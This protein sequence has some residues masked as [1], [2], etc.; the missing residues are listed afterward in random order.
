MS[1]T[2]RVL[3]IEKTSIHDG[4]GLR[5]VVFLKGCPLRCKWCST[6]ESQRMEIEKRYGKDMTVEE[7]VKE[8]CKDEIFFFHS[9]EVLKDVEI[10]DMEMLKKMAVVIRAE[11]PEAAVKVKGE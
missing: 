9:G 3:R 6:P 5:T 7:V 10:P 4:E 1:K 8:I 2:G 11:D